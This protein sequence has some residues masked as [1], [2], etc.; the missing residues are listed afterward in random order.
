[1]RLDLAD[2]ETEALAQE[3]AGIIVEART[4]LSARVRSLS[5]FSTTSDPGRLDRRRRQ[6]RESMSR[7]RKVGGES[8]GEPWR[9]EFRCARNGRPF[10]FVGGAGDSL[11]AC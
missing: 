1:M 4:P 6:S 9:C 2:A 11:H 8:T 10:V 5:A 7:R 3:L